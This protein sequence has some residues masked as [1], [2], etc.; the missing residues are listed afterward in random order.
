MRTLTACLLAGAL[1]LPPVPLAAQGADLSAL[2]QAASSLQSGPGLAANPLPGPGDGLPLSAATGPSAA[3]LQYRYQQEAQ[4]EAE[5]QALKA[6]DRGPVRFASDLFARRDPG[7]F[8]TDGGISEDY[9]LGTGDR[10]NLNVVGSATFAVPLEVDGRGRVVIPKVGSAQVGGLSLGQ[11]RRAVQA[12]VARN[13][14]RAQ[15]DLQVVRLR[16]VR[17][18]ILGEVYKPGSYLVPSLGS[19]VN[20][21]SLSGGPTSAGSYRDIRVLR[22]GQ[23]VFRLDLYPLR[24]EGIGN[25]NFALQSGDTVFV[26]L[27]AQ[28][29]VLRGAF[30]RVVQAAELAS[31]PGDVAQSAETL[32]REAILRE[33]ASIRTQLGPVPAPAG[34]AALPAVPASGGPAPVPAAPAAP[35]LDPG[36][37]QALESRLLELNESLDRLDRPAEG[38][39]R[40]PVDPLTHAPEMRRDPDLPDWL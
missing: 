40:L 15:A 20:V 35:A 8:Q 5:I 23:V 26:P 38:D 28:P 19:L 11:A 4:A 22:G 36:R 21:L 7:R 24:A 37:R 27:A 30:T 29:L 25:P 12:L 33:I 13:F 34:K 3:E 2:R 6:R 16:E 39:R 1:G 32:R 9:V 18:S 31:D 17:V 14:S 10:L